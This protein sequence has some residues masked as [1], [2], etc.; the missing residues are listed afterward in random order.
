M[1]VVTYFNFILEV[2]NEKKLKRPPQSFSLTCGPDTLVLSL[3]F[4]Y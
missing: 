4:L 1:D 3:F 2:Q